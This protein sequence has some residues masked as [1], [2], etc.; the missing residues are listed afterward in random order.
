MTARVA[1]LGSHERGP[2]AGPAFARAAPFAA[3][4]LLLALQP[5]L[6]GRVDTRWLAVSRGLAAG[7][8]LALL[9]PRYA[10]LRQAIDA[11]MAAVAVAVGA[12]VFAAW[13]HLD[14]GWVSFEMGRGFVP[15]RD[16]GLLD[17]WLVATRLA[18]FALAV[19]VMEE[20][21][22]R[23]FV[24]R[25]IDRRDFLAL[26]PRQAS[27]L[28]FALSSALFALEHSQWLAGLV[29]GAA[30]AGL[31]RRSG[32]IWIPILSHATTNALLG[33]WILATGSWRFW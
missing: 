29:A 21:F 14:S 30:Y 33:L 28:A 3:F 24:M 13:I 26:D 15:L 17:P 7:A 27:L 2:I 12:V 18:T 10:E 9:W 5:L 4:I 22:W 6:E 25:W 11:R 8:L 32:N 19:P 23:S 20:L 1:R 31:Y 16:D